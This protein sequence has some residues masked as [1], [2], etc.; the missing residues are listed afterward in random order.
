MP[1][2]TAIATDRDG[3]ARY[4]A[5]RHMDFDEAVVR[6]LHLPTNAHAREIRFLE[7]NRLISEMMPLEALDFGVAI[8]GDNRHRLCVLD[9]TPSQWD[10]IEAGILPLPSGWT[11]EGKQELGR[12]DAI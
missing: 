8:D 11:L 6:I 7:V 5:A 1:G 2:T 3:L 12:R 4:Y 10:A 9:V